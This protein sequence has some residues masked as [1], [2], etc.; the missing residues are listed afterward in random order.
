MAATGAAATASLWVPVL[1]EASGVDPTPIP[2]T[3]FPGTQ[4][5]IQLPGLGNEPSAITNLDGV[6][7]LA[8]VSGTGTA[9]DG[10]SSF[11]DA[12]MRFIQGTYLGVDN[13]THKGVFGFV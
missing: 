2:E 7:G 11:F 5:H 8:T 13:Q 6:V 3:I 1:A 12:D 4:F 10:K 9:S